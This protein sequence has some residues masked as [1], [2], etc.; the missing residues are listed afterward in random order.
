[1]YAP[2]RVAGVDAAAKEVCGS[3]VVN[4]TLPLECID[5]RCRRPPDEVSA[6]LRPAT[7]GVGQQTLALTFDA[8][9]APCRCPAGR[10]DCHLGKFHVVYQ[11]F[12]AGVDP[13]GVTLSTELSCNDVEVVGGAVLLPVD[14]PYLPTA[15]TGRVYVSW[16]EDALEHL[17]ESLDGDFL[18]A[19]EPMLGPVRV[20]PADPPVAIAAQPLESGELVPGTGDRVEVVLSGNTTAPWAVAVAKCRSPLR[21]ICEEVPAP[22]EFSAD[23]LRVFVGPLGKGAY[24][25]TVNET[26]YDVRVTKDTVAPQLVTGT[27]ELTGTGTV[28]LTFDEDVS[29]VGCEGKFV[30]NTTDGSGTEAECSQASVIA[31]NKVL[32]WGFNVSALTLN[33]PADLTIESGA[34]ADLAGNHAGADVNVGPLVTRIA[35]PVTRPPVALE[36]VVVPGRGV[37]VLFDCGVTYRG[38]AEL[39]DCGAD[40]DCA[41]EEDDMPLELLSDTD[42][43]PAFV[44]LPAKTPIFVSRAYSLVLPAGAVALA[45]NGTAFNQL[46]VHELRPA[47]KPHPSYALASTSAVRHT[48]VPL[49]PAIRMAH[50]CLQAEYCPMLTTCNVPE[51]RF[52]E[53]VAQFRGDLHEV[54]LSAILGDLPTN[55]TGTGKTLSRQTVL[56]NYYARSVVLAWAQ[57]VEASLIPDEVSGTDLKPNLA[58]YGKEL[59]R[60]A[61]FHSRLRFRRIGRPADLV[62]VATGTTSYPYVNENFGREYPMPAGF[63]TFASDVMRIESFNFSEPLRGALLEFDVFVKGLEHTVKAFRYDFKAETAVSV[64]TEG[65]AVVA[66]QRGWVRVR[67]RVSQGDFVLAQDL[68][69]CAVGAHECVEVA[70]CSNLVGSYNCTCPSDLFGDGFRESAGGS[71]CLRVKRSAARDEWVFELSHTGKLERGWTI[72]ELAC[73]ENTECAGLEMYPL[74]QLEVEGTGT[75]QGSDLNNMFDYH[76]EGRRDSTWT[77]RR[78]ILDPRGERGPAAIK[79]VMYEEVSCI[80]I[81]QDTCNGYA[82][83]LQLRMGVRLSNGG[84]VWIKTIDY[85]G[86]PGEA[87]LPQSCGVDGVQPFGEVVTEIPATPSACGCLKLCV[88]A[89]SSGCI[90]WKWYKEQKRCTL[91]RSIFKSAED[92]GTTDGTVIYPTPL[93]GGGW[94]GQAEAK[95]PGW[96]SGDIGLQLYSI[97]PTVAE[98]GVPFDLAIVGANFPKHVEVMRLKVLEKDQPCWS[99]EIPETVRGISCTGNVCGPGPVDGPSL[100]GTGEVRFRVTIL[101]SASKKTYK[102]CYCENRCEKDFRFRDVPGE[103]VVERSTHVWTVTNLLTGEPTSEVERVDTFRIR[104]ARR[105]QSSPAPSGSFRLKMVRAQLGCEQANDEQVILDAAPDFTMPDYA[106][107][108]NVSFKDLTVDPGHYELCMCGHP[109]CTASKYMPIPGT[110][111]A[112]LEVVESLRVTHPRELFHHGLWSGVAGTRASVAIGGNFLVAPLQSK[113][114]LTSDTCEELD[115]QTRCEADPSL[116]AL[117]ERC[118]DADCANMELYECGGEEMNPLW[119]CCRWALSNSTNETTTLTLPTRRWESLGSGV[120][121]D[122]LDR[123]LPKYTQDSVSLQQCKD[124]CLGEVDASVRSHTFVKDEGCGNLG[125]VEIYTHESYHTLEECALKCWATPDCTAFFLGK[126]NPPNDTSDADPANHFARESDGYCQ[127]VEAACTDAGGDAADVWS[128]YT[129]SHDDRCIAISYKASDSRCDLLVYPVTGFP[130]DDELSPP[131]SPPSGFSLDVSAAHENVSEVVDNMK[132]VAGYESF[133]I[134]MNSGGDGIKRYYVSNAYRP[135]RFKVSTEPEAEGFED[136]FSFYAYSEPQPGMTQYYVAK[137]S[138]PDRWRISTKPAGPE[139]LE[140][141]IQLDKDHSCNGRT[142]TSRMPLPGYTEAAGGENWQDRTYHY[143]ECEAHCLATP[144]C[145]QW[146]SQGYPGGHC[147]FYDQ[148]GQPST[149]SNGWYCA[150]KV[151][152]VAWEDQFSFW[153]YTTFQR[154]SRRF[155]VSDTVASPTGS[156]KVSMYLASDGWTDQFSFYAYDGRLDE[157]PRPLPHAPLAQGELVASETHGWTYEVDLPLTASGSLRVCV[158]DA[159]TSSLTDSPGGE[160]IQRLAERHA[161]IALQLDAIPDLADESCNRKCVAIAPLDATCSLYRGDTADEVLCLEF[162]GCAEACESQTNCEAFEM[163][164]K[165]GCRLIGAG[166]ADESALVRQEG[167]AVYSYVDGLQC[168]S[169]GDFKDLGELVVTRRAH[170]GLEDFYVDWVMSPGEW[171]SIEVTGEDLSED[172][173]ILL[174]DQG[175]TCGRSEPPPALQNIVSLRR[176]DLEASRDADLSVYR[177]LGAGTLAGFASWAPTFPDPGVIAP[178][179]ARPVRV[180]DPGDRGYSAADGSVLRF[181]GLHLQT[182]GRAKVCFCDSQAA[183]GACT[184]KE[185]FSLEL[186]VLHGSGVACLLGNAKLQRANCV[187]QYHGGLRC[188]DGSTP[189]PTVAPDQYEVCMWAGEGGEMGGAGWTPP[190]WIR[191]AACVLPNR[192]EQVVTIDPE[193][194]EVIV[195]EAG[196]KEVTTTYTTTLKGFDPVICEGVTASQLAERPELVAGCRR[197]DA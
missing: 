69:E 130:Y 144:E 103:L 143:N 147:L 132:A 190:T 127:L 38:H 196:P 126:L 23:G 1:V 71:G 80:R 158:C 7:L 82:K 151:G 15:H 172:D 105:A 84:V 43:I 106:L 109:P 72:A 165:Y 112:F 5:A 37:G 78:L 10:R 83:D 167:V 169:D 129:I 123:M 50:M 192:A 139:D 89:A 75:M 28:M 150:T 197:L 90:V 110:Q 142:A 177:D 181:A 85:F 133:A 108:E 179:A 117:T 34:V 6:E 186:G 14:V 152:G 73:Y 22:V 36:A 140:T 111:Q 4:C 21:A 67:T 81:L 104:V 92:F 189:A 25:L 8:P 138:D 170:A 96:V 149:N 44:L 58:T 135:A 145:K 128:F 173:R 185:H 55:L 99:S 2:A 164:G 54:H 107:W 42:A 100:P 29:L 30:L 52:Y 87:T 193:T 125:D 119:P 39:V 114:L 95:W 16:T 160:S 156:Q 61:P 174:V 161:P 47:A 163:R 76:L 187:P 51:L 88:E 64:E 86:L 101:A 48:H 97:S 74:W 91:L 98:G 33:E 63:A 13:P 159:L 79:W 136:Q 32:V 94:W 65:G 141:S 40:R 24:V 27:A 183:G 188:Y 134:N 77:S 17:P 148:A 168:K 3:A 19:P 26:S 182:G 175:G 102:A 60:P 171:A 41:A 115:T 116:Y 194:G 178:I 146:Q 57:R 124:A 31:G 162:D 20:V 45:S 35:E 176:I 12:E 59:F 155:Y 120:P 166:G 49:D 180:N 70:T 46:S 131:S 18:P 68:D 137:A 11:D 184:S 118:V 157:F 66:S 93:D 56:E 154:G 153:A 122:D 9:V 121:A 195:E 191:D 62:V 53:E 113:L